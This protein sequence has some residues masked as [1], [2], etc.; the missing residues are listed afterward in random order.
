MDAPADGFMLSSK[1]K[2]PAAAKAVLEYIGTGAAEAEYLKSDQWD[3]GLA[4]GLKM[5]T[6]NAI[7]KKS[8]AEIAKCKAVGQFMDRDADPAMATAM[9]S[10]IQKFVGDPGTSGIASLQKNAESQAKAIYTG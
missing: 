3:V 5:P 7:Q 2:N 1:A 4:K 6:Y 10:L 9:I 8:V